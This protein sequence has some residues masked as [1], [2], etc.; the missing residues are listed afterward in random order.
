MQV[1]IVFNPFQN[2]IDSGLVH[3][4]AKLTHQVHHRY[5]TIRLLEVMNYSL[6]RFGIPHDSGLQ[7]YCN[8]VAL[9]A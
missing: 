5:G 1:P 7:I 8:L 6:D 4:L 2:A 9:L 3:R